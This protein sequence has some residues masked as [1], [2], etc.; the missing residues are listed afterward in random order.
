LIAAMPQQF[1]PGRAVLWHTAETL[2]IAAAGGILL[3]WLGFPAGLVTGS[4]LGVAV[5]ALAG[6]PV[7]VPAPLARVLFVLIGISLG[8]V[9]TPETLKGLARFPLSVAVL[10]VASLA[11]TPRPALISATSM[12]GTG[13]RRCLERARARWRR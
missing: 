2:A 5:A 7:D 8:A 11:M 1:L 13:C 10:A 9:V 12:A 6:R 4:L 3:T